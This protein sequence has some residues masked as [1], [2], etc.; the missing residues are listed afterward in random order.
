M[1]IGFSCSVWAGCEREGHLDGI[2]TYTKAMWFALQDIKEQVSP[3]LHLKPYAFGRD[4]PPMPFGTPKTLADRF[5]YHVILSGVL[6]VPLANSAAI[7]KDVE[8]FHATDHQIPQI[9]GTPVVATVMDLIP[10]LHP[11]W[12]K[13]DLRRVKSW[14]FTQSIR[15]AD[16]IITISEYSKQDMVD[17]LGLDPDRISVT[18]LGVDPIYFERIETSQRE[19]VLA[20]YDVKPGFF[21]VIGTLQPRKNLPRVLEAFQALPD[22]FR[23]THPLI[24]VGRDGWNNEDL[25]PQLKA[26]EQA[27]EGKWLSYL[28]QTEVFA[29]LQSAGALVFASLYEGFGLPVIEAFAAQCPVIASNT[30]SLPE[31]TADAAWSVDP[32]DARSICNAMQDVVN[33]PELRAEKIEKGLVRA[34]HYSWQACARKTLAVYQKV[35][36]GKR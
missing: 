14:L 23:K 25:I 19:A 31:V 34:R 17:Y 24:V 5:K 4:F 6:R 2:G 27:G 26:L 12:I 20:K 35:L 22:E 3:P 21:L 29:L 15:K 11:E 1:E 33:Q 32:L 30:T 10:Q 16:H 13:Q 9:Q 8:I 28:P 18:P 7:G 36:A